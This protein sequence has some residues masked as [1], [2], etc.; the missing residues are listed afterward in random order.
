MKNEFVQFDQFEVLTSAKNKYLFDFAHSAVN[1]NSTASHSVWMIKNKINRTTNM[2]SVSGDTGVRPIV[3]GNPVNSTTGPVNSPT[4]VYGPIYVASSVA[5]GLSTGASLTST[6]PLTSDNG[7]E[8]V[9]LMQEDTLVY[10]GTTT[11]NLPTSYRSGYVELSFKTEKQNCIV[12]Y[13]SSVIRT[14]SQTSQGTTAIALQKNV[15]EP[16]IGNISSNQ[17]ASDEQFAEINEVIISIKN[18]KLCLSYIDSYGINQKSFEVVGNSVVA[19]GNWH[20]VVINI[21]RPGLVS[22]QSS[23]KK[24]RSIEF[25]IDGEL[26]KVDNNSI[27]N[28]QVFFPEILWLGANPVKL[29]NSQLSDLFYSGFDSQDPSTL[30]NNEITVN[31]WNGVW[32]PEA[33]IDAFAGAIRT[34][35]HG[36]NIPLDKFEI[37][38]RYKFWKYDELPYRDALEAS[39]TMLEPSVTVNKKRALKLFWNNVPNKNG[40]ELDNN[41]IVDSYSVTHKNKNSSTETFNLDL[42]K[43]KDFNILPNVRIALTDNV[44]IWAPGNVSPQNFEPTTSNVNRLGINQGNPNKISEYSDFSGSFT[45]LTFSG[46]ELNSGDRILLTNQINKSENGVWVFNGKTSPLTRPSD[47]DSATKVNSA[48]VYVTEGDL[49]ETYWTLESTVASFREAQVWT[50]LESK[51]DTTIY[52][53]PF[54]TSRWE[55]LVGNPRFIDINNDLTLSNYD[56][57]VFMNYPET[58]SEIKEQFP[59]EDVTDMYKKFVASVKT[60]VVNGASLYV[61]SPMLA[62]DLKIVNNF[63]TIPQLT[64]ETDAQSAAINPFQPGEPAERYFDTHRNN[65]YQLATPVA[66]LTDKETYILTDFI[67]YI[68]DNAY[69]YEQYHAK[70]A[71]RQ[72]G[73]QE[74]NAWFIPGLAL[75]KF[76]ENNN[77]PGDRNNYRGTKDILAVSTENNGI[78]GTVVTKLANNYYNGSTVT[79]NPYDDY[80]TTIAVLPGQTLDGQTIAGKVFMNVVEDGYTFSRED[81]NK[82]YVQTLPL[83]DTNETTNTRLWQYSTSRLNRSSDRNNIKILTEHGQTVPTTGGGGGFIQAAS[84]AS[85]GI[86]RSK[87]DQDNI[88]YES[89]YYPQI[90]EEIYSL[91]EIP[92]LSMTWLGLKWLAE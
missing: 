36:L 58:L 65:Q 80:A 29:F 21:T 39:A 62:L 57:I 51:P 17:Y 6:Y 77:L 7:S 30:A 9:P 41:F 16:K 88:D 19:D 11:S 54:L 53:Q 63:V 87:T 24:N 47:A 86:I 69:D 60:A 75:T 59:D 92:V 61:S 70:Y 90:D 8:Q 31:V 84:N 46:V 64:Q 91:Q 68:P 14:T 42:A 81:Y 37:Q 28:D 23:K 25:W 79:A 3:F 22:G 27:N 74:G 66:G 10:L 15:A 52:S 48:I 89:D 5:G 83:T 50:K 76:T 2:S 67:N 78:Y 55:D 43:K 45:N 4:N 26:D 1:E 49:A 40:I 20:H 71:Y 12:G 56:L 73:L 72:T 34:F 13:G 82:A 32:K 18:G 85:S 33:E 38:E 35:A 44:L